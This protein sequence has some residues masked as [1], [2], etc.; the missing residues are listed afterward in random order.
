MSGYHPILEA[1]RPQGGEVN[2]GSCNHL[3]D[4][5]DEHRR[6]YCMKHRHMVSTWHPVR[7][8]A[9]EPLTRERRIK[10]AWR[11]VTYE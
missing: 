6:G 9:F 2:C 8:E 11:G 7:C 3:G 5:N 4:F 1:R 10:V